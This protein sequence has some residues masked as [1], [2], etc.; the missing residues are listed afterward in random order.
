MEGFTENE[1]LG[2]GM[3]EERGIFHL[4]KAEGYSQAKVMCLK[5]E[6]H[7]EISGL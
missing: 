5:A 2:Q 7:G 6:K 3:K 1:A 4:D